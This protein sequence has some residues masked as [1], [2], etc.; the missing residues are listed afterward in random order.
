MRQSGL[1]EQFFALIKLA[2]ELN[3]SLNKFHKIQPLEQDQNTLIEYEEVILASGLPMNEI[4]LRIE[5]LRQ[6]FYFL[7]CPEDRSCADLSRIVFNEDIVHFVY[8][9][10]N[11]EYT[12]NLIVIIMKLLKIPLP[13]HSLQH[14]FF[15]RQENI[16]EFDAVEDVLPIFLQKPFL[17]YTQFD[18]VLFDL[19]K[20]FSVGPSYITTNLGHELYLSVVTE[21][22]M[23]FADS[24]ETAQR[25]NIFWLLW[26][27]FERI[28]LR[29]DNFLDKTT[30]EKLKKL[31]SKIKNLLRRD[32]NRNALVF[33]TEYAL[34]EYELGDVTKMES[35]FQAA[36]GE[37][38]PSDDDYARSDFYAA[39]IAYVELLIRERKFGKALA[40]LC[41][42]AAGGALDVTSEDVS[43][44][45]KLVALKQLEAVLSNLIFIERNVVI[46]ELEQCFLPDYLIS[47]LKAKLYFLLLVRSKQESIKEIEILL[48][49]FPE[50]NNRHA[51]VRESL[52]EVYANIIQVPTKNG[53]DAN[54]LLFDVLRRGLEEF[55]NNLTLCRI[56]ATMEGQVRYCF[57][58]LY[59]AF[60][61]ITQFGQ[62]NRT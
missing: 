25:R 14:C 47:A 43:D 6:N 31:R 24:M 13:G 61:S 11:R 26:L 23:L 41:S 50:R 27:K 45:R 58:N 37:T 36:L 21:F 12:F 49:T 48:R 15:T 8:P 17:D 52:Y 33:Y 56:G 57:V 39:H 1:Y 4:W 34:I 28:L 40:V 51:F 29:L 16:S 2:L 7:P 32:E 62:Q 30:P 54:T 10:A 20:D 3:V 38:R 42:L 44:T 35:I 55:P 19:I 18:A 9:L 60:L 46:M 5:K 22:L 59:V 53:H